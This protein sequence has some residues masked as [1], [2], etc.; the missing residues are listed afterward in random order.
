[1]LPWPQLV[2]FH[3]YNVCI[4]NSPA[5]FPA[6]SALDCLAKKKQAV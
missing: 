5:V 6:Y 4:R 2:S 3:V 1:M